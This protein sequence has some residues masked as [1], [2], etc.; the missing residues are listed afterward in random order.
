MNHDVAPAGRNTALLS[1]HSSTARKKKN[2][3]YGAIEA[4]ILIIPKLRLS[5]F[6]WLQTSHQ[7]GI[8]HTNSTT[9][10]CFNPWRC[11]RLAPP[12]RIEAREESGGGAEPAVSYPGSVSLTSPWGN[13]NLSLQ[14]TS[15]AE[16]GFKWPPSFGTNESS[17]D[18]KRLDG[19]N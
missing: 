7:H 4:K 5:Q 19:E 10:Y 17:S 18:H 1:G 9:P 8:M 12:Q 3:S 11:R 13:V 14:S 15:R 2:L 16:R 6:N